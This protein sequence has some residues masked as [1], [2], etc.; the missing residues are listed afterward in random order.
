MEE[1]SVSCIT[2]RAGPIGM[3]PGRSRPAKLGTLILNLHTQPGNLLGFRQ[4]K[5]HWEPGWKL[6]SNEIAVVLRVLQHI[7]FKHWLLF[8]SHNW[9]TLGKMSQMEVALLDK[10]E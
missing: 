6:L 5:Q 4:E 3:M 7:R 8:M 10:I 1:G 9:S 2:W